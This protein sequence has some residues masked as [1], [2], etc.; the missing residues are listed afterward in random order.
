MITVARYPDTVCPKGGATLH[1]RM[2]QPQKRWK[3]ECP[4]VIK[5]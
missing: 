1:G 3:P 5:G 4:P 2:R